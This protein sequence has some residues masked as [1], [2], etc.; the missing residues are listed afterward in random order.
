M[1]DGASNTEPAETS[2]TI[3]IAIA[4]VWRVALPLMVST[5][6]FSLVLFV[7]RT[8]LLR[9]DGPSMS[10]A[11]AGGNLF[12]VLICLPVGIASMTGAII[13]QHVGAGSASAIGRF[14]WQSIWMSLVFIPWFAFIAYLAPELFTATG[15]PESLISAEA[16]YLR[17]LMVG[18]VGC[19]LE[20][21]LSGFY[22]GTQRT[23]V[24]M[25]VSVASGLLN[26]VLDF[27]L[28][29]GFGPLPGMG[30]TGAA[31]AS[32]IAFWFKAICYACLLL[33]GEYE[34]KY[35]FRRGFG[36]DRKAFVNLL[37]FGFPTGLMYLTEAGGFTVMVLRIGS[38]GDVP[39]RATTMAIN[40]NMIAFIPLVGVSIAASVL[41]GRHLTETG[42]ARAAKS[43]YAALVI[44]A[45][46]S[47]VWMFAYLFA[48]DWMMTLYEVTSDADSSVAAIEL[49]KGLLGFVAIYVMLDAMQ[50]ILA[51]ALRGAGDTWFVLLGGLLASATALAIGFIFEPVG[52]DPDVSGLNWWWTVMTGWVCLLATLM[53][54]RFAA[55][56]WR[57]MSMVQK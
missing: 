42:A 11:M 48:G 10:A 49:A 41:V 15:Q 39:L 55:G 13:S 17:L 5:A 3:R 7:D 4:E 53:A 22:S 12:W 27:L 21:A 56:R 33:R 46:Y 19:V 30:I 45:I 14:L 20:T 8:L 23:N 26:L 51:G 35:Q 38:L 18:A 44:G 24:I 43:V 31:I 1:S 36:W 9:Y 29:F 52:G 28:I 6:T 16:G 54:L 47:G 57:S 32:V 50:L 37:F 2:T 40:F 34:D 25:W